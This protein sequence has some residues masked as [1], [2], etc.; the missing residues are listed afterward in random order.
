MKATVLAVLIIPT[1]SGGLKQVQD[2]NILQAG[3]VM[4]C[5]LGNWVSVWVVF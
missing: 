5:Q 4:C 3:P 1:A 2:D